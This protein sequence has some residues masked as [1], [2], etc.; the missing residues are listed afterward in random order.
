[1]EN[2]CVAAATMARRGIGLCDADL[3][4]NV[5]TQSGEDAYSSNAMW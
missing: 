3:R 1:V 2:T 4:A 5:A